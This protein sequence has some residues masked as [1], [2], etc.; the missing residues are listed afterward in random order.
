LVNET[1]KFLDKSENSILSNTLNNNSTEK[2]IKNKSDKILTE[3]DEIF[4]RETEEN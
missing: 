1:G 3:I 4:H 2:K